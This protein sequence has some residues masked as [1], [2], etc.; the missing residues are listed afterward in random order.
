MT[1]P[2][3]T[4][5]SQKPR[6]IMSI[7][8]MVNKVEHLAME[9]YGVHLETHQGLRYVYFPGGAKVLPN[10]IITLQG[11]QPG[12]ISPIF[13]PETLNAI[14]ANPDYQDEVKQGYDCTDC[15][16]MLI[17][18]AASD[19]ATFLLS[20]APMEGTEIKNRLYE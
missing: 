12:K 2:N 4:I 17:S 19:G 18:Q 16:L 6:V 1:F 5:M 3:A 10:P 14:T 13:G 11:C 15:V 9:L 7:E 8:V 20:L